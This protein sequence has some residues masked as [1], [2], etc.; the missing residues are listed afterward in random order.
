MTGKASFIE[1]DVQAAAGLR[2]TAS[3]YHL[4][5]RKPQAG[6]QGW[7]IFAQRA[8]AAPPAAMAR[9]E[10]GY[11]G[12]FFIIQVLAAK[13]NPEVSYSSDWF[14]FTLKSGNPDSFL[15]CLHCEQ[16]GPPLT[17]FFPG[18]D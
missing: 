7:L 10:C 8:A 6:R 15:Y 16:N 1:A 13:Q 17:T 11:C 9:L 14:R 5:T 18:S 2:E 4:K 3:V 12:H